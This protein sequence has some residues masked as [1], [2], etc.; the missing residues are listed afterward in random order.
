MNN[1][2]EGIL[3]EVVIVYFRVLCRD[4]LGWTE[5]NHELPQSK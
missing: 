4:F 5:E 3:K 2:L 1:E